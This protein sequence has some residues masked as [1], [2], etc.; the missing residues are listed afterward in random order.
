MSQTKRPQMAALDKLIENFSGKL[1]TLKAQQAKVEEET[2][3]QKT[4][5]DDNN[6]LSDFIA[7]SPIKTYNQIEETLKSALEILETAKVW[8]DST[9]DAETFASIASLLSSIQGL[10]SEFTD[11][12]KKQISYQNAVNMENLK[13]HNK[14]M[15]EDHK[16]QL[17]LKFH[18]ETNTINTNGTN[19]NI[20]FNTLDFIKNLQIIDVD[21]QDAENK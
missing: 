15:L 1:E 9:P 2:E 19:K 20:P 16:Y 12:W 3:L 14:K 11:I 6:Q 17:K 4:K 13:F 10:F 21:S 7:N 8:A 18:N 5:T